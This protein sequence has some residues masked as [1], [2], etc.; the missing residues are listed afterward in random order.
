MLY[1]ENAPAYSLVGYCP[2]IE[3]SPTELDTVYTLLKRS[4]AMGKKL[5]Q[6]DI[7]IVM[8]QAIYAKAQEIV[9]QRNREF[10]NVVLRMG[11]FHVITTFLAVIGKRYAAAGLVDILIESGVIAY[12][13]MNGVLDGRHYNRAI[14][15]TQDWLRS[16]LSFHSMA[17]A[18][19]QWLEHRGLKLDSLADV[20]FFS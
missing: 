9:L 5:G 2:V 18:F 3:A 14:K 19:I 1:S 8:D 10:E 20:G 16:S 12:G 15:S 13:S 7:I 17:V 4:V 11:S 6:D